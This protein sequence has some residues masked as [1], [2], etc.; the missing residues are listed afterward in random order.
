M[1]IEGLHREHHRNIQ[2]TWRRRA[3][4]AKVIAGARKFLGDCLRGRD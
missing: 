3:E 1:T 2:L 4:R